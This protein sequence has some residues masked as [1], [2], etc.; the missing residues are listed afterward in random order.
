MVNTA[1]DTCSLVLLQELL[2]KEVLNLDDLDR[3][4]G[5]R[6]FQTLELRNVDK[7]RGQFSDW[8]PS[9]DGIWSWIESFRSPGLP[10]A[11]DIPVDHSFEASSSEYSRNSGR[12]DD[13][14]NNGGGG[15]GGKRDEEGGGF[16]GWW[17]DEAEKSAS[18]V[19]DIKRKY[20]TST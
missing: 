15:G 9:G 4:L 7:F 18:K 17:S 1:A 2:S 11:F 3:I 10:L 8:L 14:E 12:D 5:K 16:T 19:Q 6:P 13:D 20:P